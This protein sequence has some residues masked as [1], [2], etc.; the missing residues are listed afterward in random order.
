MCE[1]REQTETQ[2]QQKHEIQLPLQPKLQK[3]I[4]KNRWKTLPE[5]KLARKTKEE[6]GIEP[7]T[8]TIQTLGLRD[9]KRGKK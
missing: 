9:M 1:K 6:G 8:A 2:N 5:I 4:E 3:K 7:N